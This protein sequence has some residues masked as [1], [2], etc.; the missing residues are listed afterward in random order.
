M[1]HDI[2]TA[3]DHAIKGDLKNVILKIGNEVNTRDQNQVMC[4]FIHTCIHTYKKFNFWR[5]LTLLGI[6]RISDLVC[7]GQQLSGNNSK[8][9]QLQ[10]VHES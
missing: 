10:P 4:G 8:K 2:W 7:F 1:W 3:C 5:R 6:F 9:Y